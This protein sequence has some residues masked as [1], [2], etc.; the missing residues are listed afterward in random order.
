MAEHAAWRVLETRGGISI[1]SKKVRKSLSEEEQRPE[2][3]RR[4]G[5][6]GI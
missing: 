1:L 5:Y 4:G 6:V 3:R 2:G